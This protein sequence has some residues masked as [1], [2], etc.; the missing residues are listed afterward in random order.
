MLVVA[1]PDAEVACERVKPLNQRGLRL[2]GFG[3][4]TELGHQGGEGVLGRRPRC[5]H[6]LL[7]RTMS[8]P[9]VFLDEPAIRQDSFQMLEA[10]R[11]A[12][13]PW[14]TVSSLSYTTSPQATGRG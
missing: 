9:Y 7:H 6:V 11:A 5:W 13:I 1:H 14:P 2:A 10:Y 4:L 3:L 8:V 12:G